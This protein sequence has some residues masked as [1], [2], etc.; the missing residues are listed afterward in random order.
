MN[1]ASPTAA[2]DQPL[3]ARLS[4]LALLAFDGADAASFLHNQLSTDVESM[5]VG[6]AGWTSYNSPKGRVLG[7]LLLWRRAADA[8]VAFVAADLAESLRKRLSMF[9]LRAKVTVA[10]R[11]AGRQLLGIAG[12][13]AEAAVRAAF[14]TVPQPGQGVALADADVVATPDGRYLVAAEDSGG[15][16]ARLAAA[17]IPP[18]YWN[19]LGV[20]SGVPIVTG[21]TQ[22]Q[23]V[24][25][26][27]NLDLIGGINFRKGCYPGQE[28]IARMQYLGRLKERL[29]AFH[30][31][32]P[33]P[34]PGTRIHAGEGPAGTVVNAA[35][36][37]NGGS[38]MLAVVSWTAV[39]AGDLR[40]GDANGPV[41]SP[42]VLP[43]AV[44]APAAPNR[45]KL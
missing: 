35:D 31:D 14:T 38:D 18:A 43:Y 41:L 5:P 10:D 45:A 44:P 40:L 15:V 37:A 24:A 22:D 1:P 32:A 25:Q 11:T 8:F 26:T 36:A 17:E 12:P 33:A 27:L 28:I 2:G 19:W 21:A 30:A 42:L 16:R 13:G 9:V 7:S 34:A 4:H 20:R 29:F 39:E 3:L 23:F 6:A